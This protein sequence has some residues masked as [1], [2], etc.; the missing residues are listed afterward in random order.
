M[1]HI[2]RLSNGHGN[3]PN[4]ATK[5]ERRL[6]SANKDLESRV[7]TLNS[8]IHAMSIEHERLREELAAKDHLLATYAKLQELYKSEVDAAQATVDWVRAKGPLEKQSQWH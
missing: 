1:W 2:K 4:K 6:T 5:R 8:R 3:A 7:D